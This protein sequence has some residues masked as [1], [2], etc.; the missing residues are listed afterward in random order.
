M[1]MPAG[2]AEWTAG[3]GSG[4]GCGG[5]SVGG[6]TAINLRCLEWKGPR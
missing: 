2:W 1:G 4:G 3:R 5:A 6:D